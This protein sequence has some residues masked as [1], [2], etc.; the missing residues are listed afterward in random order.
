[1]KNI[2]DLKNQLHMFN[3]LKKLKMY[4][5]KLNIIKQKAFDDPYDYWYCKKYRCIY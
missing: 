4:D 2:N 3:T 5:Q 1:M